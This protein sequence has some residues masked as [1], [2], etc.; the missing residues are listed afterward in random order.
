MN[1]ILNFF[2][3]TFQK[4]ASHVFVNSEEVKSKT[5]S[6][7][8]NLP[9]LA[10]T[11]N[12]NTIKYAVHLSLKK[13]FTVKLFSEFVIFNCSIKIVFWQFVKVYTDEGI[14][15]TNTKN[16]NGFNEMIQD[17]LDGKID[18]ELVSECV[19]E[20]ARKKQSQDAYT[21]K[22]NSLVRRYER[23]EKRLNK[24][25][26]EREDKVNKEHKLRLFFKNGM[27]FDASI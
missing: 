19:S 1:V 11:L 27:R 3:V 20:N 2:T 9:F 4:S 15:G 10:L 7:V 26:A 5:A 13:S 8:R 14:S 6:F 18:I 12:F 21:K 23:A 24:V 17:A 16:R 22:Y 25:T